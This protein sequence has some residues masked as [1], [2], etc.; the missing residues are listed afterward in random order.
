MLR[1]V[2]FLLGVALMG[3]SLLL[4]FAPPAPPAD[5][6]NRAWLFDCGLLMAVAAHGW[7][8]GLL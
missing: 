3:I 4:P 8:E 5:R 2:V 7:P 1:T 6:F